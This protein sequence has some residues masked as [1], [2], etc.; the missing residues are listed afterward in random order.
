MCGGGV[1]EGKQRMTYAQQ[2]IRHAVRTGSRP[3]R[4]KRCSAS[5]VVVVV[6]VVVGALAVRPLSLL[7]GAVSGVAA[8]GSG[9]VGGWER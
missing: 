5:P 7:A 9:R 4:A 2:Q 3:L 1:A 6:V 8:I